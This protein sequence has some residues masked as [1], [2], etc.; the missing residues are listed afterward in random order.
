MTTPQPNS[1]DIEQFVLPVF[2]GTDAAS[3][4]QPERFRGT[5]FL[6]SPYVVLTCWHCVEGAAVGQQLV[7]AY[8]ESPNGSRVAMPL[9]M[10]ERH[11][12]GADLAIARVELPDTMFRLAREDAAFGSDVWSYGYPLTVRRQTS[13]GAIRFRTSGRALRGYI[14]QAAIIDVPGRGE[15]LAYEVDMP[16]PEGL[17]GAPLVRRGSNDVVGVVFGQNDVATIEHFAS[18]DE[19]TGVKTPEL[20]RVHSFGLAHHSQTLWEVAGE[21]T[22]GLTLLEYDRLFD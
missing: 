12:G 16:A 8:S 18:V 22:E 6:V 10:I 3:S 7:V 20:Q 13:D 1:P 11:A 19:E 4:W 14:T 21:A 5:A 17:S 2:E 15:T 9:T